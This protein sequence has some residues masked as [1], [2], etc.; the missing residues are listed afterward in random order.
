MA[1][2]FLERLNDAVSDLNAVNHSIANARELWSLFSTAGK[3]TLKNQS[4][5]RLT[6]I[7]AQLE[8]VKTE[9]GAL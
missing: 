9:I 7:I 6:E 1:L 5:T 8:T 2:Q 4:V 3:T